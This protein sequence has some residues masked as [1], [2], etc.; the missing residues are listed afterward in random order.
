[1]SSSATAFTSSPPPPTASAVQ[2]VQQPLWVA[3]PDQWENLDQIGY[4]VIPAIGAQANVISFQ[5]PLGRNGIIKKVGNNFVGGGWTEGAGAAVWQILVD[6]APPPGATSYDNILAS[7]GLPA[8]P[9]EIAGFRIYENQ[10]LTLVVKNISVI[11]AG[12]L[13]GGRLLGYLYPREQEEDNLW[14]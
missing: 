10:V 11:V 12:Q 5:V 14:L 13:S 1:M 4:I 9:T 7:L 2:R 6:G 8:N 3:P